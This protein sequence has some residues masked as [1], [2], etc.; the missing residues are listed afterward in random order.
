MELIQLRYF[1]T[2]AETNS[3]TEAANKLYVSRQ[4][5][6]KAIL[7]L[8][9]ELETELFVRGKNGISLTKTGEYLYPE[10]KRQMEY[11]DRL[12][13]DIELFE[14][15]KKEQFEIIF[16]HCIMPAF[17]ENIEL[18]Q[19]ENSNLNVR[20]LSN[21]ESACQT[22]LYE[23]KVD[24]ICISG[25]LKDESLQ[26]MP[27]YETQLYLAINKDNSLSKKDFATLE[28]V[29]N[30]SMIIIDKDTYIANFMQ[31]L[32][33]TRGKATGMQ[34]LFTNND[35]WLSDSLL[36]KNKGILILSQAQK[37]FTNIKNVTFLPLQTDEL[38]YR[39]FFYTKK[40]NKRANDLYS[41]CKKV[42][43]T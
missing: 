24:A 26:S 32:Y 17:S 6:S 35:H 38:T 9:A 27:V 40:T 36:E 34:L 16:S 19:R 13:E 20:V 22:A 2:A 33:S 15:R 43:A 12:K 39:L 7:L 28:D 23:D 10:I 37:S 5:L 1:I 31:E 8:E 11:L 42:M 21:T 4:A 18:H 41:F 30:Q 14:G 29:M 3:F 25:I